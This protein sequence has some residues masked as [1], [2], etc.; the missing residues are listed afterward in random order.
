M[1]LIDELSKDL[2]PHDAVYNQ[3]IT[4]YVNKVKACRQ[5]VGHSFD[6]ILECHRSLTPAQG[7][8][9]AQE[10]APYRPLFIEDPIESDN[11]EAMAN[12]A[13]RIPIPLAT[14]ECFINLQEF[15]HLFRADGTQYVRPDL[16]T[17]GGLT[18]G[19]KI[20]SLAEANDV[21][22]VPH[23]PLGPVS[24]AANLQLDASIEN[25]LIQEFPSFYSTGG[26][27]GMMTTAFQ[28]QDGYIH[29]PDGPGLGIDLIPDLQEK[30]P[31]DY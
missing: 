29:I 21:L 18:V 11:L 26:E 7:L 27:A 24:T 30:F 3:K 31:Q 4:D 19:K 10:V 15:A 13:Q 25:L 6:L 12:L 5:A 16:C 8:V 17:V 9:L 14:G 23:N 22:L 2:G 20:A 1:L 28:V